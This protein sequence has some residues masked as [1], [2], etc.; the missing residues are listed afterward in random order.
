MPL[1]QSALSTAVIVLGLVAVALVVWLATL[2]RSES[3]LRS[4]LR[5]ILSDN[6]T[7]GLDEILD[8]QAKRIE[9]L[10]SRVDALNALERELEATSRLALQ[11]VGVVRFNPFQGSGGDQSFAI[12]LLDQS[13]TGVVISSLHGR[14][15][16]RIFAKQVANGRSRHALSDEEQQAIRTAIG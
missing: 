12:A 1:D 3:R 13:G 8:G 11:K 2:Q 15:E 6:G 14:A 7:A 4:R 9:Q 5:R 10:A 16:T